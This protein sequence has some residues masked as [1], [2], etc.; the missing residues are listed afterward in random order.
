MRVYI[1]PAQKT[2]LSKPKTNG[3]VNSTPRPSSKSTPAS[4]VDS[5][6][7]LPLRTSYEDLRSRPDARQQLRLQ[8][9][10]TF[11]EAVTTPTGQISLDLGPRRPSQDCL[12]GI[13]TRTLKDKVSRNGS[14]LG[15][16]Q[17]ASAKSSTSTVNSIP[18]S[19]KRLTVVQEGHTIDLEAAINLLQELKKTASPEELVALHR[20]LLPTKDIETV[21]NPALPEQ[22]HDAAN[23][24]VT[25][26]AARRGSGLPP[27]LATRGG[28]NDDL[29]RKPDDPPTR[30]KLRPQPLHV[31]ESVGSLRHKASNSKSSIAALDL[32]E[33]A[34]KSM[35]FRSASPL[36]AAFSQIGAYGPGTLRVTNGAAS[37]EPSLFTAGSMR[38]NVA[39]EEIPNAAKQT[40]RASLDFHPG[41]G[42]VQRRYGH[43]AAL[44]AWKNNP[45]YAEVEAAQSTQSAPQHEQEM[46]TRYPID[47][48]P[49]SPEVDVEVKPDLPIAEPRSSPRD[50]SAAARQYLAYTG[51][52]YDRSSEVQ[53]GYNDDSMRSNRSGPPS[54][55]RVMI[56][57]TSEEPKDTSPGYFPREPPK[58]GRPVVVQ[59]TDSGYGSESST[60]RFSG[61]TQGSKSEDDKVQS[62]MPMPLKGGLRANVVP[63][64]PAGTDAESLYTFDKVLSAPLMT[65]RV[66]TPSPQEP[67]SSKRAPFLMSLKSKR[68]SRR[69]VLAVDHPSSL[70][71]HE[72]IST[73]GSE[74]ETP[75][76]ALSK[77]KKSTAKALSRKLKKAVPEHVKKAQKS[78]RHAKDFTSIDDAVPE[79]RPSGSLEQSQG[80]VDS[81]GFEEDG[82]DRATPRPS[83]DNPIPWP[84][85]RARETSLPPIR[86]SLSVGRKQSR[87]PTS[88]NAEEQARKSSRSLDLQRPNAAV[89]PKLPRS[90]HDGIIKKHKVDSDS[91][92]G[93]VGILTRPFRDAVY[94]GPGTLGNSP[95]RSPLAIAPVASPRSVGMDAEAASALAR[96]RSRDIILRDVDYQRRPSQVAARPEASITDCFPEWKSKPASEQWSASQSSQIPPRSQSMF[97]ECIP[98]M[99]ELPN[100]V[101]IRAKLADE[102][103]VK[104]LRSSPSSAGN[105]GVKEKVMT[106]IDQEKQ[107]K[108]GKEC[109]DVDD[110]CEAGERAPS[111]SPIQDAQ[112]PGWPGWEKQAQLWKERRISLG[113]TL[114]KVVEL[115]RRETLTDDPAERGDSPAIVVSR[116]ITPLGVETSG[117]ANAIQ[118][119]ASNAASHAEAYRDLIGEDKENQQVNQ[120]LAGRKSSNSSLEALTG[121]MDHDERPAKQDVPRWGS[122]ISARSSGSVGTRSPGGRVRTP[123]GSFVPYDPS[124][125]KQVERS[126]LESLVRL[127][128]TAGSS[129]ES[130]GSLVEASSECSTPYDQRYSGGLEYE[131][132][133]GVGFGGSAG[134]RGS[135]Q[136]R[137]DRSA[138]TMVQYGLDFGTST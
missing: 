86:R 40:V 22:D 85:Q 11:P 75:D 31:L 27:G 52:P 38:S 63:D 73:P 61:T 116:Y 96:K 14:L 7:D 6:P 130:L 36:D 127:T 13:D 50:L 117:H 93:P 91:T 51:S 9:N 112:H 79:P 122:A 106:R 56:Q 33:Q 68:F 43:V 42:H 76:T 24:H 32:A 35:P 67:Q 39:R 78:R 23:G 135:A 16:G 20:A 123:S 108:E 103:M 2:R 70:E 110:A 3:S 128:G 72:T 53:H 87:A 115:N 47:A 71:S 80:T 74:P 111:I 89:R 45:R 64:A 82:K 28:V 84:T 54:R 60:A 95:M 81:T 48:T 131:W 49:V 77:T 41:R 17:M 120:S 1:P 105:T 121:H 83:V 114:P 125:A 100:D 59:H 126:R 94:N 134:T 34:P 21:T 15:V 10:S 58:R 92:A 57:E 118:D 44:G 66:A 90:S 88:T 65:A 99:P 137:V 30:P 25:Q 109:K 133:R 12:S 8:F 104:K 69:K 101:K 132:Q 113:V 5:R 18:P 29:L 136:G 97:N 98:P 55:I 37:P 4:P 26:P 124:Y 138:K 102:M 19:S 62:A 119:S 107:M 46:S 129:K